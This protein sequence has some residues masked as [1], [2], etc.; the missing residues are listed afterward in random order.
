MVLGYFDPTYVNMHAAAL[1]E[2][3]VVLADRQ[4]KEIC[5]GY[6]DPIN[7]SF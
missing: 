1:L 7:I 4:M 3:V 6:F 5:L 2:T